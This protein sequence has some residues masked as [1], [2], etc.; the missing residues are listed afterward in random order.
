MSEQATCPCAGSPV[1][2]EKTWEVRLWNEAQHEFVSTSHFW[3]AR[4]PHVVAV[5]H[6]CAVW[7]TKS[8]RGTHMKG[9]KLPFVYRVAIREQRE[10]RVFELF[11]LPGDGWMIYEVLLDVDGCL[12]DEPRVPTADEV[13]EPGSMSRALRKCMESSDRLLKEVREDRERRN[14]GQP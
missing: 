1:P 12:K 6:A 13:G 9:C 14:G 10:G 7:K 2:P 11:G 4:Y 3:T 8:L 5:N